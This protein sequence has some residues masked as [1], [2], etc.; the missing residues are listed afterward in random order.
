M[1]PCDTLTQKEKELVGLVMEGLPNKAIGK[2]LGATA[3]GIAQRISR[4]CDKTGFSSRMELAHWW[5]SRGN[6]P[7]RKCLLC[8]FLLLFLAVPSFGAIAFVN[9]S[10]SG[11]SGVASVSTTLSVT[12]GN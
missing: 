10:A 11:N 1:K 12:S 7:K 8:P 4:V 5:L 9:V 3:N 2:L 6:R